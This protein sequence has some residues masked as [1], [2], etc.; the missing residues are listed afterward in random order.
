MSEKCISY[1]IFLFSNSK[2]RR[3][4]THNNLHTSPHILF[5]LSILISSFSNVD[6]SDIYLTKLFKNLLQL[7]FFSHHIFRLIFLIFYCIVFINS[8]QMFSRFSYT[9]KNKI[10]KGKLCHFLE[11]TRYHIMTKRTL[12]NFW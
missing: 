12:N 10:W 4:S 5:F 11:R 7:L 2:R 6:Q 9:N 1:S 3:I 8:V